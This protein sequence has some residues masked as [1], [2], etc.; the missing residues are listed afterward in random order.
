MSAFSTHVE[1]GVRGSE[2]TIP[3]FKAAQRPLQCATSAVLSAYRCKIPLNPAANRPPPF[4][5]AL[6]AN[7]LTAA[8]LTAGNNAPVDRFPAQKRAR[9]A[10]GH[11]PSGLLLNVQ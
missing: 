8:A 4:R 3:L 11:P 9:P 10:A 5:H 7:A 6:T 2:R 1:G